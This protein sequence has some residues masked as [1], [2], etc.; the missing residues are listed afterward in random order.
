MVILPER[1]KIE[2]LRVEQT[3]I[4][5][6]P[7]STLRAIISFKPST[8][9]ERRLHTI[10]LTALNTGCRIDEVLKLTWEKLTLIICS[11]RS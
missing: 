7:E 2:K 5:H 1:L 4:P 6:V 3:V 11:S 10:L 9:G 8:F